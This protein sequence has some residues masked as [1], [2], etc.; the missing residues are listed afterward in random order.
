MFLK[1]LLHVS[2]MIN[3]PQAVSYY[4]R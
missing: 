3:Q 4:V 2:I 1:A